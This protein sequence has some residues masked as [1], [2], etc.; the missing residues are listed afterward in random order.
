MNFLVS[1]FNPFLF[2][3]FIFYRLDIGIAIELKFDKNE[4]LNQ[5]M[6]NS[7][8]WLVIVYIECRKLK[9]NMKRISDEW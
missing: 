7:N 8:Y 6:S 4:R 1:F 3:S 5:K 9:L 2:L